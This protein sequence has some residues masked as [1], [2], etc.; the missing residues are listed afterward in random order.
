M[1]SGIYKITSPSGKVYIGQARSFKKRFAT[2]KRLYQPT[3]GKKLFHSLKKYGYNAHIIEHIHILPDNA[4]QKIYDDF[5]MFYIKKFKDEG[6]NLLNLTDGGGGSWGLKHND[7]SRKKISDS[8]KGRFSGK[9]N[10]NYGKGC[11]G[12]KNGIYGTKR[13][14][15]IIEKLRHLNIGKKR[16]RESILKQ[17]SN[18]SCHK[19]VVQFTKNNIPIA[20]YKSIN[21]A[22]QKTGISRRS[23]GFCS[24][25]NHTYISHDFTWRFKYDLHDFRSSMIKP[26]NYKP[27]TIQLRLFA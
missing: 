24:A 13:P 15:W 6:F 7:E 20:E 27:I 12:K 9:N 25:N 26:I 17:K 3:I 16:S 23:I 5:E 11:F 8:R 22:A 18:I 19:P 14:R 1:T 10:P 4:D 21:E 2:Y